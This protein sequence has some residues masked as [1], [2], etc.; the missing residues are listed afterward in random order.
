[1][2]SRDE[3]KQHK[4]RALHLFEDHSSDDDLEAGKT[5]ETALN[6]K[7]KE[8]KGK[9]EGEP[10][11]PSLSD[12]AL[13]T[14]KRLVGHDYLPR[15]MY[16]DPRACQPF[17]RQY[18][19]AEKVE[20]REDEQ[21]KHV[22]PPQAGWMRAERDLDETLDKTLDVITRK[23][24]HLDQDTSIDRVYSTV[25][26]PPFIQEEGEPAL[27]IATFPDGPAIVLSLDYG[28]G[29]RT[30]IQLE[31]LDTFMKK[32]TRWFRLQD[33][34]PGRILKPCEVFHLIVGNGTGGMIAI[35]L[36]RLRMSVEEV[37]QFYRGVE[38]DVFTPLT[39]MDRIKVVEGPV[40][41]PST[42]ADKLAKKITELVKL[43]N[44]GTD[45]LEGDDPALGKVLVSALEDRVGGTQYIQARKL[46]SHR[47]AVDHDY[48]WNVYRP[49]DPVDPNCSIVE[50]VMATVSHLAFYNSELLG[51]KG[52]G[53]NLGSLARFYNPLDLAR[54]EVDLIF[55]DDRLG[56]RERVF[57]SIGTGLSKRKTAEEADIENDRTR[58]DEEQNR[59][60]FEQ[61]LSLNAQLCSEAQSDS[62][63]PDVF[64]E[65]FTENHYFRLDRAVDRTTADGEMLQYE[66]NCAAA[67]IDKLRQYC[68]DL[69]SRRR[70]ARNRAIQ[71]A[72]ELIR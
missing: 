61:V 66:A 69:E 16:A 27:P 43:R 54:K 13:Q 37:I 22:D 59:L 41:L 51:R 18:K 8:R 19:P 10:P 68:M 23:L 5:V 21:T 46:R 9:G 4:M 55:G 31:M 48:K 44:L 40:M 53:R 67:K 70:A 72:M 12:E 14:S 24:E 52:T 62:G 35:L 2:T 32:L 60:T 38:E 29:S 56:S 71:H 63:R 49:G 57:V 3:D 45:L 26:P 6:H 64:T 33:Q 50:A 11:L 20:R 25:Q 42:A 28:G 15:S 58:G 17:Q 65:D 39:Q 36:G 47:Y 1:M 34:E 30:T 7:V